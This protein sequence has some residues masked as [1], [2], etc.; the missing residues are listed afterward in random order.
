LELRGPGPPQTPRGRE[1]HC[2]H[3]G[4]E[5]HDAPRGREGEGP[6]GADYSASH[7]VSSWL[8]R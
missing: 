4:R 6:P 8:F 7:T 2:P 3:W 1:G 5:G